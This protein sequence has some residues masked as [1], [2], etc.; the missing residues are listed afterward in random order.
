MNRTEKRLLKRTIE[1]GLLL[2]LLVILA[3]SIGLLEPLEYY[4]YDLRARHCQFFT[5]LPSKKIVH[6]DINDESLKEIGWFPWPR[7]K[8]AMM[9]DEVHLAGA[10]IVG[11]DIIFPE[12][13]PPRFEMQQDGTPKLIQDDQNFA[14]AVR[15]A[16]NVLIPLSVP[17]KT[18]DELPI[19][20]AIAAVLR[21]DLEQ[22]APEVTAK[23][24]GTRF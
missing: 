22:S 19:V 21:D 5:P 24:R 7:T 2:T 6:L 18:K 12:A 20:D 9:L 3:D 8:L 16:G 11:F 4:L 14:D 23:L 13:Q 15:R 10:K 1:L 17:P